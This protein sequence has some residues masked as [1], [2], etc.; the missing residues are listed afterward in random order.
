MSVSLGKPM[1]ASEGYPT[2]YIIKLVCTEAAVLDLNLPTV[3]SGLSTIARY[4]IGST[5]D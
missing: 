1:I 3:L 4:P 5:P 2:Q